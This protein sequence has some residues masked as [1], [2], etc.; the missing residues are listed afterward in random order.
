[1]LNFVSVASSCPAQASPAD[2]KTFPFIVLGNKVDIGGGSTRVV[3]TRS[4][5]L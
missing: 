2:P 3:S 4:S 1:M 5:M